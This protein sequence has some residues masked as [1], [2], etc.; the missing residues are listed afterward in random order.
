MYNNLLLRKILRKKIYS[1]SFKDLKGNQVYSHCFNNQVKQ[2]HYNHFIELYILEVLFIYNVGLFIV[3]LF[4]RNSMV[5][6]IYFNNKGIKKNK[7][8]HENFHPSLPLS[9]SQQFYSPLILSEI[10]FV[11][12]W[13][14][15]YPIK[16][17]QV[18]RRIVF[19]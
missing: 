14:E 7:K 3:C 6:C 5:L 1:G 2:E 12:L 4:N 17:S 16:L 15:S 13:L 8:V 18:L 10:F 19:R 11:G 9:H